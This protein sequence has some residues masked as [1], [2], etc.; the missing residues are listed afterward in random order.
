MASIIINGPSSHTFDATTTDVI[1]ASAVVANNGDRTGYARMLIEGSPSGAG[2]L[3]SIPP[4]PPVTV[5]AT[6]N[7]AEHHAGQSRTLTARLYEMTAENKVIVVL[8][9]HSQAVAQIAALEVKKKAE[10]KPDVKVWN[11]FTGEWKMIPADQLEAHLVAGW[12]TEEPTLKTK[13]VVGKPEMVTMYNRLGVAV[14]IEA[15]LVDQYLSVGYTMEKEEI[16]TIVNGIPVVTTAVTTAVTTVVA[17]APL[18]DAFDS[19]NLT[20]LEELEEGG[21]FTEGVQVLRDTVVL[22]ELEQLSEGGFFTEGPPPP[23]APTFDTVVL[24]ELE[25]LEEGGFF[26]DA[27]PPEEIT[28]SWDDIYVTPVKEKEEINI[29]VVSWI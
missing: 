8:G 4:G 12:V 16:E 10:K 18:I 17:P 20:E 26:V 24:T 2:D 5:T 22:T 7:L 28:Y 21:F 1:T 15:S 3:T 13:E 23:P 19:V 29:S 27:P 11:P 14:Q 9:E 6:A 25:E